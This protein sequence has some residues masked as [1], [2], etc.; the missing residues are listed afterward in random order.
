MIFFILIIL[1][2]IGVI[3][4]FAGFSALLESE[5]KS[6]AFLYG[7]VIFCIITVIFLIK[8]D[9]GIRYD[10]PINIEFGQVNQI[11]EENIVVDMVSYKND[12]DKEL[13][14]LSIGDIVKVEYVFTD[15]NGKYVISI[16]EVGQ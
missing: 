10:Y 1:I 7:G 9:Y 8:Y 11:S 12:S 6:S 3:C 13:K 5:Y 15:L 2:A 14:G 16:E 4:F